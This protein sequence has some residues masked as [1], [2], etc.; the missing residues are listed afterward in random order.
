MSPPICPNCGTV[1][2][3]DAKACPECGADDETGWSEEAYA[4]QTPIFRMMSLIY[5]KYAKT[6]FGSKDPVPQ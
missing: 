3:S 6:E 1:L 5:E 2:P 4:P